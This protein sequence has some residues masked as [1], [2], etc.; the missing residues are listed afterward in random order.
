VG[1]IEERRKTRGPSTEHSP[2]N[3]SSGLRRFEEEIYDDLEKLDFE[4]F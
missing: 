2:R 4:E 3:N 1:V